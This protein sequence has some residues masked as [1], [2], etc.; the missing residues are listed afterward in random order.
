MK[1]SETEVS[2]GGDAPL[3]MP[4]EWGNDT[5]LLGMS[6]IDVDVIVGSDVTYFVKCFDPLIK[7]L[8]HLCNE[9]TLVV[10]GHTYRLH[11]HERRLQDRKR[12][13]DFFAKLEDAGFEVSIVRASSVLGVDAPPKINDTIVV[14]ARRQL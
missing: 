5:H 10:F 7:T 9:K 4:L 11:H 13:D 8:L 2:S 12:E 14:E 6:G 3:V 1:S